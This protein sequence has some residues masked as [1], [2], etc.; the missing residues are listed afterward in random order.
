MAHDTNTKQQHSNTKSYVTKESYVT[1]PHIC[2]MTK[3]W[4]IYNMK[5]MIND[6]A[7]VAH[8]FVGYVSK[9]ERE[10]KKEEWKMVTL[11]KFLT[12]GK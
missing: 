7:K 11:N 12:A 1:I 10:L 5:F 2:K 3:K 9:R 8:N 4:N 6:W